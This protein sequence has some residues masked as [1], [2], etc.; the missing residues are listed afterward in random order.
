MNIQFM[1]REQ[2]GIPTGGTDWRG[3]E[4]CKYIPNFTLMMMNARCKEERKAIQEVRDHVENGLFDGFTFEIVF[5]TKAQ[6]I[7]FKTGESRCEW[8]MFQHPWYED[9]ETGIKV[10]K[11]EM[12]KDIVKIIN[13]Y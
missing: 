8:Q 12:L 5:M 11:A 7:D 9:G 10:S 1:T 2:N 13:E 4:R 6:R 3:K